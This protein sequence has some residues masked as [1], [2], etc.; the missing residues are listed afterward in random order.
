MRHLLWHPIRPCLYF[1]AHAAIFKREILSAMI[2]WSLCYLAQLVF[3][4][5]LWE[6]SAGEQGQLVQPQQNP[7]DIKE[8]T[9]KSA[10]SDLCKR[11]L[12]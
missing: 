11:T 5:D 8:P 2:T 9:V 12:S 6:R 10:Q 1:Q 3:L 7:E 4:A